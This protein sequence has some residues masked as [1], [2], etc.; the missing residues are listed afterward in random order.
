MNKNSVKI[1]REDILKKTNSYR[2]KHGLLELVWDDEVS[3]Q[4]LL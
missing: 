1:I 4:Y 3:K 2:T